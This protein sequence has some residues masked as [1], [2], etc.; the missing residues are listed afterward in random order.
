M[1]EIKPFLVA[2]TTNKLHIR[3]GE[4]TTGPCNQAGGLIPVSET[5]IMT[6]QWSLG[7]H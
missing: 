4:S 2:A 6:R 5:S 7:P 1:A 3:W